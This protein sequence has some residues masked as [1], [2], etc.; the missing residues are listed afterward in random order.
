MADSIAGRPDGA[1]PAPSLAELTELG[2]I[3]PIVLYPDPMLRQVC[4][5]VKALPQDQLCRLAGDLLATM[6]AAQGRG[7]AAPQIGAPY[8]IFVM[9]AGWKQ[10]NPTP[11]VILDPQITALGQEQDVMQEGC[12]SIPDQP[13]AVRRP[14]RIRLD[15]LGPTGQPLTLDLTGIEARIAQHE[16]D[17]LDGR[18][19]LDLADDSKAD[20]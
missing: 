20:H 10:G 6:Y 4:A 19:I 12:L 2:R 1:P 8:R 15:H 3:R 16:A 5:G 11:R 7:L 9:D 18:L 13:V 14:V 17:H